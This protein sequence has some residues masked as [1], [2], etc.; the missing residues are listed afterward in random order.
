MSGLLT[1]K[2]RRRFSNEN[3][4]II[5]NKSDYCKAYQDTDN[6][7]IWYFLIKGQP[8]TM[9]EG[10][11]YIGKI[12]RCDGYYENSFVQ[13]IFMLTPNGKYDFNFNIDLCRDGINPTVYWVMQ[14][15]YD[16]DC[17]FLSFINLDE[18]SRKIKFD[19]IKK[20]AVESISYNKEN[21]SDI[22]SKFNL[23]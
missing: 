4:Q 15:L 16:L 12:V 2:Q 21:L 14:L 19:L 5:K 9:I 1:K 3:L 17:S 20:L 8:D 11:E 18:N 10:G 7:Y 23:E 6:P 22:Y 13:K